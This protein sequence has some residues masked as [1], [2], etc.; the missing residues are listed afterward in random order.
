MI[1]FRQ[2]DFSISKKAVKSIS[3]EIKDRPVG[4]TLG[5]GSLGLS[6]SNMAVNKARRDNEKKYQ[7]KQITATNNLTKAL[8]EY[9][10][11]VKKAGDEFKDRTTA[12][13]P[14]YTDAV[15]KVYGTKFGKK[16][17]KKKGKKN[18]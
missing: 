17:N 8:E 1:K 11:E 3:N 7:K 5:V 10:H 9:N 4:L 18:D 13:Y 6:V 14:S 16:D 15:N 12:D 2:K